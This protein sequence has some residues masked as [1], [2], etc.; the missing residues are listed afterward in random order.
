MPV[1]GEYVIIGTSEKLLG[2]INISSNTTVGANSV[3]I[4]SI[5]EE[6]C[7]VSGVPARVLKNIFMLGPLPPPETGQSI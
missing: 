4:K 2:K 5:M 1:I 3:V 7:I 6:G